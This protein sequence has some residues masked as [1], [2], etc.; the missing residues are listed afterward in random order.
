MS[1]QER[2]TPIRNLLTL[3]GQPDI[4]IR[5]VNTARLSDP[6]TIGRLAE[7][8]NACKDVVTLRPL[9]GTREGPGTR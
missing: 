6:M 4:S 9:G 7:A 8:C 3:F 5:P 2:E 1:D